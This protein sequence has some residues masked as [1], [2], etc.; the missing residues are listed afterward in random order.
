[1][2]VQVIQLPRPISVNR[3]WANVPGKGRVRTK[4]YR[5]WLRAAGWMIK[6]AHPKQMTG[7]CE[8]TLTVTDAYR[9]DLDGTLKATLDLFETCGVVKN[10][11]Q[12]RKLTIQF[13]PVEG[14]RAEIAPLEDGKAVAA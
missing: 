7:D 2:T 1:M 8:L 12:F 4:D 10:D 6:A 14:M 11:R 13:G 9:G 3:L 5:T